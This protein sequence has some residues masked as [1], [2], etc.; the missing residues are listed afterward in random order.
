VLRRSAREREEERGEER[1][2]RERSARRKVAVAVH[3]EG[4]VRNVEGR[5]ARTL[6]S[7]QCLE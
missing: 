2:E 5:R 7:I 1:E 4:A 3:E 6:S